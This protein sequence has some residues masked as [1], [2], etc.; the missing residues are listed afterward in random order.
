MNEMKKFLLEW[1]IR[2]GDRGV[3]IREA[4]EWCNSGQR[5]PARKLGY[6]T[7]SKKMSLGYAPYQI[8][9]EGKDYINE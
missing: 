5:V 8:T 1:V 6:L 9:Q 2:Y 3:Q 4:N 7:A